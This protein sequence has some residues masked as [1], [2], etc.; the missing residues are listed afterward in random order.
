[1]LYSLLTQI[2]PTNQEFNKTVSDIL[3]QDKYSGLKTGF[4]SMLKAVKNFFMKLLMQ[5]FSKFMMGTDSSGAA[6]HEKSGIWLAALAGLVI[7]V[8]LIFVIIKVI[9]LVERKPKL[10]E[11]LGEVINE[12]T[13]PDSLMKKGHYYNE[14]GDLRQAVRYSFIAVLLLMHEKNMLYL[15]DTKT[16]SEMVAVLRKQGFYSIEEFKVLCNL[17][18]DMWYGYE[19]VNVESKLRWDEAMDKVWQKATEWEGNTE[20]RRADKYGLKSG[21]K[22]REK[23]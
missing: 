21:S 6:S 5:I 12:D 7:V 20:D 18:N 10:K 13:T 19:N 16:N 17:F 14:K 15:D 2:T 4:G 23:K 22:K 1:M 9:K 8:I 11:I 3:N